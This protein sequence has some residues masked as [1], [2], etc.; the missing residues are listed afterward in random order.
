MKS[1]DITAWPIPSKT[2]PKE[3]ANPKA[4]VGSAK[5][6]IGLCSPAGLFHEAMAMDDGAT[7]YGAWN[8]REVDIKASVYLN[9]TLRHILLY[10][11]GEEKAKDS[12]VHHLGHAKAC[13][14][15]WLDSIQTGNYVDDRPPTSNLGELFDMFYNKEI[16]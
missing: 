6:P 14:G 15:I 1:G 4:L 16:K 2:D 3:A 11:D 12:G 10:F 9:A 8:F 5:I 13:L 7:K